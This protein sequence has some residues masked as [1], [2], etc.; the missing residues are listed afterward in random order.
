MRWGKNWCPVRTAWLAGGRVA[1]TWVEDSR[2]ATGLTPNTA[3]NRDD[4]GG[5]EPTWWA[6][7]G[8]TPCATRPLV[9]VWGRLVA[10]P[11]IMSEKNTPME[12]AVPVFWKVERI[13]EAAPRCDG[14]T[15]PMI[16]EELGAANIPTPTPLTKMSTPNAQ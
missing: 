10:S 13:P 11:A 8:A 1:R 16:E 15:L 5:S 4:T 7:A 9:S 14:G 6:T 12:S 3:A 2:C